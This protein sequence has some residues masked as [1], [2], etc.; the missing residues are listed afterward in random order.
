MGSIFIFVLGSLNID[1]YLTLN[2][3]ID[4]KFHPLHRYIVEIGK[5]LSVNYILRF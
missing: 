1:H 2:S 5:K 4:G 3:S